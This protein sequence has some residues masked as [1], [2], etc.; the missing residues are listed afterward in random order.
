MAIAGT[1]NRW[2]IWLV[3]LRPSANAW[4]HSLGPIVCLLGTVPVVIVSSWLCVWLSVRAP[5]EKWPQQ[6]YL[7][8]DGRVVY[9]SR[10]S[11]N[12]DQ[13]Y[14]WGIEPTPQGPIKTDL[15]PPN[16]GP[17]DA[18]LRGNAQSAPISAH[19]R[20]FGFPFSAMWMSSE[21]DPLIGRAISS[22]MMRPKW[23]IE[24]LNWRSPHLGLP[25]GIVPLG[26]LANMSLMWIF[27]CAYSIGIKTTFAYFRLRRNRCP[28]CNYE[29][30]G[31]V[32]NRC[33]ECGWTIEMS[34]A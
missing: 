4:R 17:L 7:L 30:R 19:Q 16:W 10:S 20:A 25:L 34:I 12:W 32:D 22:H 1:M 29:L 27:V 26:F 11:S 31:L 23:L 6:A 14:I 18:A 13:V 21:V 5:R 9:F 2:R 8:A 28:M 15:P 24:W 3:L 33:P